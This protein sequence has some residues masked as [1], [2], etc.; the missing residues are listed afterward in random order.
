MSKKNFA[1]FLVVIALLALIPNFFAGAQG[2]ESPWSIPFR[3]SSQELKASEAYL[4]TDPF[5][6]AHVFWSEDLQDGRVIIKYSRYDGQTWAVPISIYLSQSE[7]SIKG[8]SPLIDNNGILHLYWTEGI[9]LKSVRYMSAPVKDALSAQRW[10]EPV[11][12]NIIAEEIR[13]LLSPDGVRHVLYNRID[14]ASRGLFYTH[15]TDGGFNW[16]P[17]T[18][19]DPDIPP[20]YI[21]DRL[22]FAMDDRGGLHAVWGYATTDLSIPFGNWIR[23]AGLQPD[24]TEW[25]K[26]TID[27]VD[28]NAVDLDYQLNAASPVMTVTGQQVIVIWAGGSLHYRH[29]RHSND[30]GQTWSNSVRVFGD[31]NGQAQDGL[32]VDG[33][34]RVHYF[35]QI[36]FPVGIYQAIWDGDRW[37]APSMVYFIR[38]GGNTTDGD[39][40]EAHFTRPVVLSGNKLVLSFTDEPPHPKRGLYV[41]NSTLEDVEA[42][43]PVSLPELQ[44]SITPPP[45]SAATSDPLLD[46][47]ATDGATEAVASEAPA[48]TQTAATIPTGEPII[49]GESTDTPITRSNSAMLIGMMLSLVIVAGIV[50]VRMVARR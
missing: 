23:Y 36:R 43:P 39:K 44:P 4:T 20:G 3:I 48:G 34:G 24:A 31:L 15:S 50:I 10:S 17:P 40:I 11:R 21:P 49:G 7:V 32:T 29:F 22:N 35:A 9:L 41:M 8:I 13:V 46:P 6:Y 33:A 5:G 27:R 2:A 1:S 30:Y 19:I 38:Y 16:T 18:W 14:A 45:T 25:T 42:I 12:H 28:L 37:S 47:S 26:V